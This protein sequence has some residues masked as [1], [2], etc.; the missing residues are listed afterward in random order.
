MIHEKTGCQLISPLKCLLSWLSFWIFLYQCIENSYK[1]SKCAWSGLKNAKPWLKLVSLAKTLSG[2]QHWQKKEKEVLEQNSTQAKHTCPPYPRIWDVAAWTQA[3]S[4]SRALK[5]DIKS[6]KVEVI[7]LQGMFSV[8]YTRDKR[9]SSGDSS[10]AIHHATHKSS[11]IGLGRHSS[12][13]ERGGRWWKPFFSSKSQTCD[14]LARVLPRCFS[15]GEKEKVLYT[16]DVRTK[17]VR[18]NIM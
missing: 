4:H 2:F 18:E 16:R 5:A 3:R 13:K 8:T 17:P 12:R 9:S 1:E 11:V 14:A 15:G 10:S 6:P 7:T